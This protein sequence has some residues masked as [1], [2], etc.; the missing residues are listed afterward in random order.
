MG[1][2]KTT[3]SSGKRNSKSMATIRFASRKGRQHK[4]TSCFRTGQLADLVP[5][6]VPR[7]LLQTMTQN[8][9]REIIVHSGGWFCCRNCKRRR[10]RNPNLAGEKNLSS[11]I[12]NR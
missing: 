1:R 3:F 8:S 5:A 2:P 11:L 6:A 12:I 9:S 10:R 7:N 4:A